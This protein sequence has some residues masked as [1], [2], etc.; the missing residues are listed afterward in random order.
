MYTAFY[1]HQPIADPSG[2]GAGGTKVDSVCDSMIAT[3]KTVD[4]N[5]WDSML[6]VLIVICVSII[7]PLLMCL[8]IYT[9]V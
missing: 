2:S 5:K 7:V 1:D 6:I 4:Y 9:R 8:F 3:L